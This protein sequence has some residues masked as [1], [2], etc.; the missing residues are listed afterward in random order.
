MLRLKRAYEPAEEADGRRILVE[1]LWPRGVAK[2]KAHL[3]AWMKEL[4]PS[5][6]LRKWYGHVLERW[7]EFRR[8]Y[9]A[10]LEQ[11]ER[12]RLLEELAESARNGPVTLVYSTH[13]TEHSGAAVLRD[14]LK[15]H[16]RI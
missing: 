8:R 12:Q 16:Y 13:D 7:P 4:A 3:D 6:D 15:E 10:E 1:R 14:Y 11:P 2:D 9:I 5:A